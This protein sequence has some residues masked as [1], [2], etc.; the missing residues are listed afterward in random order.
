MYDKQNAPSQLLL[1]ADPPNLNELC[2]I[3]AKL[4][5]QIVQQA[6]AVQPQILKCREIIFTEPSIIATP[7]HDVSNAFYIVMEQSLFKTGRLQARFQKIGL[8]AS[9]PS[10]VS[11]AMYQAC[12]RYTLVARV[13][14]N[15]N[16]TGEWLIQGR[17]FLT[18]NG[19]V[20][21]VKLDITVN[22]GEM[23]FSLDATT[24]KFLPLQVEDLDIYGKCYK[25]FM[26]NP[27]A[28]IDECAIG[29]PWSHV[30]PSMKKGKVV[31][32]SHTLPPNGPFKSYKDLKRHWKNTYGYRLPES[33]NGV[34]YYQVHFRP[35]G[36][37]IFTYPEVCLR[38]SDIQRVPRVDPRPILTA[39]LQVVQ[40]KMSSIC[41]SPLRLQTKAKYPILE[42]LPVTQQQANLSNK[43][44]NGKIIY[45]SKEEMEIMLN[46]T[47]SA[48]QV[49]TDHSHSWHSQNKVH[50]QQDENDRIFQCR[51]EISEQG[52]HS[53]SDESQSGYSR[54][55]GD[56]IPTSTTE[57]LESNPTLCIS[58][59]HQPPIATSRIV[60]S[61]APKKSSNSQKSN[62]IT[63]SGSSTSALKNVPVF[64]PKKIGTIDSTVTPSASVSTGPRMF[65]QNLQV[66]PQ[67]SSLFKEK[68]SYRE[69]KG[70]LLSQTDK[71][72]SA[73]S[74]FTSN[75]VSVACRKGNFTRQTPNVQSLSSSSARIPSNNT[76]TG[77]QLTTPSTLQAPALSFDSTP[78]THQLTPKGTPSTVSKKRLKQDEDGSPKAKKPRGKPQIQGNLDI[79][80]FARTNQLQKANAA[81]LIAWLKDKG[82]QYKSK[83]KKSDLIDRVK[84]VLGLA[85][86]P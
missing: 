52:D 27:N 79:E 66:L 50:I 13:A 9:K 26:E 65:E 63:L 37:R 46:K 55:L 67:I 84:T 35:L 5:K 30:L 45:R 36:G 10:M 76:S 32:V 56:D 40:S 44:S 74:S 15:W 17:D 71:A 60:P 68:E 18:S 3:T 39:F 53:L 2:T 6:S 86:E 85:V 23:F 62:L 51:N 12:L 43:L 29:S 83:D 11:P 80:I 69:E 81:T 47:C 64:K 22:R 25:E 54:Q 48:S 72:P 59:I 70:S 16:K 58:S 38:A 4:S 57:S 31:G 14:P 28:E 21:A 8:E 42:L 77:M 34:I 41:G 78:V 20:N 75:P 82:I 49:K 1:F 73:A 24:V 7:A 33:E 61:F 19:Y